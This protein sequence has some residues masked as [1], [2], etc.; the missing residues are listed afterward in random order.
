VHCNYY[1]VPWS[2]LHGGCFFYWIITCRLW[3]AQSSRACRV[4]E[5]RHSH[6]WWRVS[7]RLQWSRN[8]GILSITKLEGCLDR[9]LCIRGGS[10]SRDM[11]CIVHWKCPWSYH[12]FLI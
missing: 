8:Q 9:F 11:A 4:Y 2:V 3:K 5:R 1:Q 10:T 12:Y 6:I 7:T